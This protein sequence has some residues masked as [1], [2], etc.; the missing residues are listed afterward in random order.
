MK[1]YVLDTDVDTF[2]TGPVYQQLKWTN[3]KKLRPDPVTIANECMNGQRIPNSVVNFDYFELNEGAKLTDILSSPLMN[4]IVI[5]EKLRKVIEDSNVLGVK[6][7]GLIISTQEKYLSEYSYMHITEIY[8]D[9]INYE[10]SIFYVGDLL[11]N[12]R[13]DITIRPK[14][15]QELEDYSKKLIFPEETIF[16]NKIMLSTSF[17]EKLDFFV[18]G[19]YDYSLFISEN[20]KNKIEE[21]KISG[22]LIKET[23]IIG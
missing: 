6:Y 16:A 11:G 8:R 20:L 18:L 3:P 22:I 4:G 5:S 7:Y 19:A 14:S 17:P 21:E 23:N 2:E 13:R 12:Y 1:Y 15:F 10:N 9:Y